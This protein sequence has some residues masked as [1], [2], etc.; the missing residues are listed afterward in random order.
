MS[1]PKTWETLPSIEVWPKKTFFG[2]DKNQAF[3][4]TLP[5][6]VTQLMIDHFELEH[7]SLQRKLVFIM[8]GSEFEAEIRLA[9]MDRSKVRKLQP[10]ELP[11]RNVVQFQWRSYPETQDEFRLRLGDE[12]NSVR[13]GKQTRGDSVIFH[14]SR[15]NRFFVEFNKKD[16]KHFEI[17]VKS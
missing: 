1:R 13:D 3:C 7:G 6:S 8:G 2:L 12:Y 14:H 9:I 5:K 10:E 17:R 15:M 11:S 4:F 16:S